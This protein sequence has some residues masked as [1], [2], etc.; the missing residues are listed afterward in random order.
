MYYVKITESSMNCRISQL[1]FITTVINK[2]KE[3]RN[4]T[5]GT[6]ERAG[7]FSAYKA[8]AVKIDRAFKKSTIDKYQVTKV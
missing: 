7:I 3:L 8:G 5:F 1:K 4:E 6:L 2:L